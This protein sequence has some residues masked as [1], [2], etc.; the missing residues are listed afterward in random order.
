MTN[1]INEP[2][3]VRR[4]VTPAAEALA[5][6]ASIFNDLQ[7]VLRCCERLVRELAGR[8]D[9]VVVEGVWTTALISYARC[10]TGGAR[11]MGL[12]EDDVRSIELPGEVLEWHKVLRQLRK[13]YADPATNPRE[14]Y[15]VGA[16]TSADGRVGG[17]AITGVPQPPLDEVTVRQTGALAYRLSALV[18]RRISE[19]Q[20]RVLAAANALSPADLGRLELIEVSAGPA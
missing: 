6:L 3:T 11:G 9:D 20:E 7:T 4:L 8:P 18:D 14:R 15:E 17:I 12:T 13:H 2:A 16:A 5:D 10:F 19:H 1:A